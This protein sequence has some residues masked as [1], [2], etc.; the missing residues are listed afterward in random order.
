[1][2]LN[3]HYEKGQRIYCEAPPG[4]ESSSSRGED[5]VSAHRP[6]LIWL[7]NGAGLGDATDTA[8]KRQVI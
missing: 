6:P 3:R 7:G 5:G 2:S 1:L 4:P 8:E